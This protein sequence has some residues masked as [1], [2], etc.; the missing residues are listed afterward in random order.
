MINVQR[1]DHI[2]TFNPYATGVRGAYRDETIQ[3]AGR[4]PHVIG[5]HNSVTPEQ[6]EADAK[7]N[8][9]KVHTNTWWAEEARLQEEAENRQSNS[10]NNER[11]QDHSDYIHMDGYHKRGGYPSNAQRAS[12][13]R[14]TYQEDPQF[15]SNQ[16]PYDDWRSI[17]HSQ[18]RSSASW[19]AENRRE[20]LNKSHLPVPVEL[21]NVL[22]RVERI[23]PGPV[24]VEPVTVVPRV[25]TL[26]EECNRRIREYVSDEPYGAGKYREIFD[27]EVGMQLFFAPNQN[28]TTNLDLIEAVEEFN[29][30]DNLNTIVQFLN[31]LKKYASSRLGGPLGRTGWVN[32]LNLVTNITNGTR[33]N[34]AAK[35]RLK[36]LQQVKKHIFEDFKGDIT[37]PE[38]AVLVYKMLLTIY[39]TFRKDTDSDISMFGLS[40]KAGDLTM[41][42]TLGKRSYYG[43]NF[44]IISV[45][46]QA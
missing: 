7:L 46:S 6:F 42:W 2:V 3:P 23:D 45:V 35:Q 15:Q 38:A 40:L 5:V 25:E 4:L 10:R 19:Q 12:E 8:N 28:R 37:E 22:P 16:P 1:T 39:V 9:V 24:S 36:E 33:M 21:L 34:A 14:R 11:G 27:M 17:D 41:R 20:F 26:S 13:E 30:A 31:Q 32:L 18:A 44:Y 29:P 43:M